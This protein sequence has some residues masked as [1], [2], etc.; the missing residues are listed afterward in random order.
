MIIPLR[1]QAPDEHQAAPLRYCIVW[2]TEGM[3]ISQTR[4]AARILLA[5]A[6]HHPSHTVSQDAQ[7][8]VSELVTNALR[9]APGP[10]GLLLEVTEDG[11]LRIT[12]RDS[13]PDRPVL[14]APDRHRVGGHGL[15]LVARLCTHFDTRPTRDGK[16]VIAE[17]ALRGPTR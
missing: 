8:V 9:H 14:L 12:V 10:G 17:L 3:S 13:S 15:H 4:H 6:G 7:I 5:R 2:G 11:R 16:Q 1:K